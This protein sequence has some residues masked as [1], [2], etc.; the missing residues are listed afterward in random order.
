MKNDFST[1]VLAFALIFLLI[2]SAC[3]V[4]TQSERIIVLESIIESEGT[5]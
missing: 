3:T 2:V 5:K 1:V 4:F